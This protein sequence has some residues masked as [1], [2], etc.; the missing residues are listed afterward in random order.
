VNIFD[1]AFELIRIYPE[2]SFMKFVNRLLWLQGRNCW[3]LIFHS[4]QDVNTRGQDQAIQIFKYQVNLAQSSHSFLGY[5][6]L[7]I[8]NV[9]QVSSYRS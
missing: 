6:L 7:L 5:F 4:E 2:I 1:L 3:L 9:V 8:Q